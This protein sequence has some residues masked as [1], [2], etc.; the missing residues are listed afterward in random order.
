MVEHAEQNWQ[1]VSDFILRARN[2]TRV[3]ELTD[4][5]S[6][7]AS[8]EAWR[9]YQSGAR[10]IRWREAEFDYF[11]ISCDLNYRDVSSVIAWSR[12]GGELAPLM[13]RDANSDS[14]RPLAEASAA[15]PSVGETLQ[16]KAERLGWATPAGGMKSP[17]PARA[18]A[19]ARHG[20]TKD[21]HARVERERQLTKK[22]RA[23]LDKLARE[24]LKS[25]H[26]ERERRYIV[27]QL[28]IGVR[29][30]PRGRPPANQASDRADAERLDWNTV[31][32][33]KEWGVTQ[34]AAWN[35]VAKLRKGE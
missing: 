1:N 12:K 31:A 17:I 24:L 5:V 26:D 3:A 11:L 32:L 14:R 4:L 16:E 20:V 9:D 6:E 13:D 10:R 33:A 22:R 7:M 25:L 23:E 15:Y 29:G 30:R 21:E 28:R 35:R 2:L 27:D 19:R 8:T 34:P 18:R